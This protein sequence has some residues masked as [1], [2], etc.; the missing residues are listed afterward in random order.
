MNIISSNVGIFSPSG[1]PILQH[2]LR[3]G[4]FAVGDH[5]FMNHASHL[6]QPR[7]VNKPGTLGY[8]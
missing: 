4:P 5:S 8:S 3:C 7:L 1:E 6:Q 2:L